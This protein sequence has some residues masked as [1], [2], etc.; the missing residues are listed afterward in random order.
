M[1]KEKDKNT[2]NQEKPKPT[3][4]KPLNTVRTNFSD[5]S[6]YEKKDI[7]KKKQYQRISAFHIRT[8]DNFQYVLIVNRNVFVKLHFTEKI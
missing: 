8:Y 2:V 5:E 7:K 1:S 6:N 4:V 3:I